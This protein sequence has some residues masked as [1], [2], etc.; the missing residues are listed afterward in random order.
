M[1]TEVTDYTD[2]FAGGLELMW[3]DGF[4]SPGG[5]EEVGLIV[6]D[7]D[8]HEKKI[9]DVGSGIGGPAICLVLQH[10]ACHVTGIDVEPVNVERANNNAARAGVS[11]RLSFN[12]VEAGSFPFADGSFDIVFSKD[13]II[14]APNKDEI[15]SESFRVLRPGGWFAIGDWFRGSAPYTAEMEA[16]LT[17]VGVTLEMTTIEDNADQLRKA[18]FQNVQSVDRNQW[19]QEYSRRE[20]ERMAGEDREKFETLLGKDET[21]GWID[22][23]NLKVKAVAQGQLRPGHLRARKP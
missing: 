23:T 17:Q 5:P 4:L 22:A 18:G 20:V 8:L 13:A 3:G 9:L 11:D 1:N 12:T 16:W 21:A 7:L 15:F 6:H 2:E 10:G 14:E 19:Y